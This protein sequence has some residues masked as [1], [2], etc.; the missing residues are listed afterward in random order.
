MAASINLFSRSQGDLTVEGLTPNDPFS[1]EE[2]SIKAQLATGKIKL[3]DAI[4]I[5]TYTA[6][7]GARDSYFVAN[8]KLKSWSEIQAEIKKLR[9]DAKFDAAVLIEAARSELVAQLSKP[10]DLA[11]GGSAFLGLSVL[12]FSV[13]TT[14]D[15]NVNLDLVAL[16]SGPV[17][18]PFLTAALGGSGQI[19]TV[20][21]QANAEIRLELT[22]SRENVADAVKILPSISMPPLPNFPA[23]DL[24]WPKIKWP[25]LDWPSLDLSG[26]AKLL[27][28][29]LP[30]SKSPV[31]IDWDKDA[32]GKS[33]LNLKF[34]VDAQKRLSVGTAAPC[35]GKLIYVDGSNAPPAIADINGFSFALTIGGNL[36]VA[37]IVTPHAVSPNLPA[38]VIDQPELLPFKIELPASTLTIQVPTVNLSQVQ[39]TALG[40]KAT[41]E[42]KRI[43]IRAKND[44]ALLIALHA[45]Y[46]QSVEA[47][48]KTSGQ[49]TTLEIIEPY[50]VKLITVAAQKAEDLARQLLRFASGIRMPDSSFQD[51]SDL[52]KVLDRIADMVAAAVR[53]LTQ[54]GGSI[55]NPLLG[56]A[57]AV[58]EVLAR[59]VHM[60]RDAIKKIGAGPGVSPPHLMIEVRLDARTYALRQIVIAPAWGSSLTT[61]SFSGEELGLSLDIKV[62]LI[63]QPSV[64]IDLDGAPSVA[65]LI[66]PPAAAPGT[67]PSATIGTDLW[68]GHD[69][70]L[71]AVRDTDLQG[72]RDAK[73]L[74]QADIKFTN[75][76]AIALVRLADGA[77]HFLQACDA[78]V[79]ATQIE[80]PG[81]DFPTGLT[82]ATISGDITYKGALDWQNVDATVS[83][84]TDRLLPFLQSSQS[85]DSGALGVLNSIGQYIKVSAQSS[86]KPSADGKCDLPVN[87]SLKINDANV[88]FDLHVNIDLKDFSVKLSGADKIAI[89]GDSDKTDFSLLGLTGNIVPKA[90]GNWPPKTK[91]PFFNLDFSTGDAHLLLAPE[92]RLDLAYGKVASGGRGIVFHVD[93]LGISRSGLDLDAKV[94]RDTPV[95]LA[96]VD[97]PFRFDS[98]G[99]SIKHGQIQAFSIKGSGQLPPELVGEANATISISMGRGSDGSLIV[100]SAE[101]K[102]DKAGDPIVCHATRFVLTISALG[103]EFQNF[104]R[105]GGGY[106]FY[107]TL[108]GTAEFR[109]GEGEFTD[110]LLKYLGSITIVLD[111]A[112]LA[113]DSSMLLRAISFQV[114]VVPPK[115]VNFFNLFSF[116]LR[117]I[118]FHP[119]SPAFGGKPALSIS[120]QVN[121]VESG[122]IVSPRFDFH[123]LWIAPPKQGQ[124]L[125][126]IRFDGLTLGVRFGGAASIEGT[127]IAV[128]G[129]LPSLYAPGALPTDVTV[130]GFLASG[131]L[132]IKGWGA[133]AA[134]MGFLE[135]RKDGGDLRRAFFLYAE[136]DDLSIEIPTPIGPIYLRE[137]GFGFGYRFTIAAFN[138]ADKVTSVK[139]LI[140]VLDDISKYQGNLAS[141]K[142]WEPEAE[143]NRVTLAL[144]GLITIESASEET[145]YN[146]DGEEDLPNPILFDIVV[147]LRSDFTFFLNARVWI[148]RNYADWHDSSVNDF[149]RNNPTLRG[150][151][152]LSVPRK[153]FLGRLI[154]D[155]TGD[156][157]GKH[158]QLPEPLVKAMKGIRWSATTYIRPGL[159]HQEFGWPYELGFTFEEKLGGGSFQIVCSGG[160]INRIEDGAMLWGIA[161]RAKGY[162]QFGGQIGGRSFGASAYARADF[163]IDAK[164]IA[165]ISVKRFSDTLFYGSISFDV[166]IGLQVRIWLEFSVGFTDIHLEVG[167]SISLTISIALEAAATPNSISARGSASVAVG[168][169]GRHIRLGVAFAVN[170]GRLDEARAR[171]ERF[172]Q[173]GLTSSM[174]DAEQAVAP[175]AP[176]LPRG[177]RAGSA[178]QAADTGLD[179]HDALNANDPPIP[180]VP[181]KPLPVPEGRPLQPT[182]YWAMLFPVAGNQPGGEEEFVMIFVPR[183]HTETGLT[184]T[185]LPRDRDGQAF[186]SFYPPPLQLDSSVDNNPAAFSLVARAGMPATFKFNRLDPTS[187]VQPVALGDM[188]KYKTDWT[189]AVSGSNK[190]DLGTFLSQC[191]IRKLSTTSPPPK[192]PALADLAEPLDTHIMADP[193]RLPSA[194]EAAAQVLTDAGRDQMSLGL[195]LRA[196]NDI[197]ERRSA[198]IASLCDSAAKLAAGGRSSWQ[199]APAA[200]GFDIRT[201]GAAFVVKKTE[202]DVLFEA[203][204]S[205]GPPRAGK[206]DIVAA[207]ASIPGIPQGSN[208][209]LFNSP[210]RMFRERGPRLAEP[211]V[212]ATP[213]GIR[214]DWDLEPPFGN[215]RGVW[216]DPEFDLKH[217][218]IER[219]VTKLDGLTGLAKPMRTT[220]KAAAPMR[221][222]RDPVSGSFVWRFV[223]PNAQFVDDLSDLP[224]AMR[225][226]IL[227]P[228]TVPDTAPT[229][230]ASLSAIAAPP[231]VLR[232]T[233]VP[234]DTA[235]TDGAPTPLVL[236]TQIVK[237]PRKGVKRAV[238]HFEYRA[239]SADAVMVDVTSPS[240]KPTFTLGIDD[241]SDDLAKRDVLKNNRRYLLR[242]RIEQTVPIGLYGSDAVSDAK[243]RPSAGDFAIR[244][245]GDPD[246]FVITLTKGTITPPGEQPAPLL[247]PNFDDPMLVN[248]ATQIGYSIDDMQRFLKV[249]GADRSPQDRLDNGPIGVRFAIQ[250]AYSVGSEAEPPWCPMD[251]SILI[252][253]I[254]SKDKL[255]AV[256]APVEVFEHPVRV[257]VAP[258]LSEDIDGNAGRIVVLHPAVKA[259][260]S[261]APATL[262]QLLDPLKESPLQRLRDSARRV[263]TSVQWN[264]RPAAIERE[265]ADRSARRNASYFG[266]YDIFE[267][268][269]VG[270][271]EGATS[272]PTALALPYPFSKSVVDSNPGNSLRYNDKV[273]PEDKTVGA[274]YIGGDQMFELDALNE[275]GVGANA[276]IRLIAADDPT[277]ALTLDL[278]VYVRARGYRKLLV[279]HGGSA[280]P[281]V[282]GKKVILFLTCDPPA[283]PVARVQA[284][285]A[286]LAQLD[287]AEIADFAKVEAHYP[288]ETLRLIAPSGGRQSGWYSPAESFLVWPKRTLRRSLSINVDEPTLTEMLS[289]GRPETIRVE[290]KITDKLSG[291]VLR[292]RDPFGKTGYDEVL[293]SGL[294]APNGGKW[295]AGVLREFLQ[296]LQWDSHAAEVRA[297]F[298]ENPD[299][300][301]RAT[302]I[303]SALKPSGTAGAPDIVLA[304]AQ[305]GIDLDPPLHP[306]LADVI[307][308]ARYAE[309]PAGAE[310]YPSVVLES[311]EVER[312]AA[313]L[314]DPGANFG[315]S[316]AFSINGWTASAQPAL[317]F[318][319]G[320]DFDFS[321][322]NFT[323]EKIDKKGVVA[324]HDKIA[325]Q[326]VAAAG[327]LAVKLDGG[328]L[329]ALK[330]NDAPITASLA[331]DLGVAQNPA[332][333]VPAPFKFSVTALKR[334][335]YRRYEPVLEQLPKVNAKDVLGWFDETPVQ[336]DPYGWSILR[337]LGLAAGIKLYDTE[338]RDYMTPAE[339]L[340]QLQAAF[341]AILPRYRHDDVG[342]PFVD[343]ITHAGGTLSLASFDGGMSGVS[344]NEAAALL[345]GPAL[346][347]A[348]ISLRPTVDRFA[349]SSVDAGTETEG[350]TPKSI[351]KIA[352]YF[353]IQAKP[354]VKVTLD[355]DKLT[356]A[357]KLIAVAEVI[358]LTTGLAKP[359]IVTLAPKSF[360]PAL[361][362]VRKAMLDGT[363]GEQTTLEIT[364]R[365]QRSGDPAT[366]AIVRV[367]VSSGDAATLF[368]PDGSV[369]WVANAQVKQ[370]TRP[371]DFASTDA[372]AFGR[373]P[374]LAAPRVKALTG[375]KGHPSLLNAIASLKS[376]TR[377]RLPEGWPSAADEPTLVAR[378]PDW[379]RRFFDHGTPTPP[380]LCQA[381]LFAIAEVT[382]PDPW[383]VGVAADGTMQVTFVHD[384]RKRRLKRYA[385]KPFGRYDGFADALLHASD[386]NAIPAPPRLGGAW[387]D[388]LANDPDLQQTFEDNWSRRFFDVVIPRTEPLAPPVLVDAKRIEILP[389][390]SAA[391]Q[392]QAPS[393]KALEFLFA[394][395]AEEI[396]SEANVTVE[397][398]LSFETVSYGFWREFPMQTW[399]NDIQPGI[400][401]TQGF[402][403]WNNRPAVPKLI[404]SADAFGG[405]AIDDKGGAGRYPEGWR[406]AL[407]LRTESLPFFFRTHVAAFAS[408]GVVVSDPVVATVEEGYYELALPWQTGSAGDLEVS[409]PAP[410]WSVSRQE[411]PLP[412]GLWVT[413]ELPL[414]RLFDSM[415]QDSRKAWLRGRAI[416]D[417]FMLP[418]PVVRYEIA[419]V[420]ADDGGMS[421]ASTELDI[422]GQQ[423]ATTSGSPPS[424]FGMNLVGPLFDPKGASPP[425]LHRVTN[426]ATW[427]LCPK[428]LAFEGT[429]LSA[430]FVPSIKPPEHPSGTGTDAL[431]LFEIKP[432]DFV[433][434]SGIAP[435]RTVLFTV[436]PPVAPAGWPAFKTGVTAWRALYMPYI[437][438]S[439]G[440]KG[441]TDFLDQWINANPAAP[442]SLKTFSTDAFIAGLPRLTSP[443]S[444]VVFKQTSLQWLWPSAPAAGVDQRAA[445]RAIVPVTAANYSATEFTA[446]VANPIIAEM[447]R[448]LATGKEI[449]SRFMNYP[450]LT[451]ALPPGALADDARKLGEALQLPDC[452]DVVMSIPVAV[453]ADP[454]LAAK[455]Q[456]LLKAVE[457][458]KFTSVAILDLGALEDGTA[459]NVELHL[460]CGVLAKA[461]VQAALDA[462]D[463]AASGGK[464]PWSLLLR[465]PPED[466]DRSKIMT[467][468]D[469]VAGLADRDALKRFYDR[470]MADQIFGVGRLPRVKAYRGTSAPQQDQIARKV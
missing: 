7:G 418:D 262:A 351:D 403:D 460:S 172:M 208:V 66:A 468:I 451:V 333:P 243:A 446:G 159:F 81:R 336:R 249:I 397:G 119:S 99:L 291:M 335:K 251:S 85:T 148:A 330:L 324:T 404:E 83:A 392:A 17:E 120:G 439:I 370:I 353:A 304:S 414:V 384:D 374:D 447:R 56:V 141:I 176:E 377:K 459:E 283:K 236:Q 391:G 426:T 25:Q 231:Y 225:R 269:A 320:G 160:M 98:G 398:A 239:N 339:T 151:V 162:A 1:I 462:L 250:P 206:F 373:F 135:L 123:E 357:S 407:A 3:R 112:P 39:A 209:H 103:F 355:L 229:A 186:S 27:R 115:Q 307:D 16:D 441:I 131:K 233:V 424:C 4:K 369:P 157:D 42:L 360:D 24:H 279:K 431:Q 466:A 171:V 74:I 61:E 57:E 366:V 375:D 188:V 68:L 221:L 153:E 149:W 134:A 44:P 356:G 436:V 329:A 35:D 311:S 122:D 88:D 275:A 449:D 285:P 152:Y 331:L 305:W 294:K 338:Q 207:A 428:V 345:T 147:A 458:E 71:E 313:W 218:R 175:P 73:R 59:L 58:G 450:S 167:F 53:W 95:Q 51:P 177:P 248:R 117:G 106:Q 367:I 107:F 130:N 281:F 395:H 150:Y 433:A 49:L 133:M 298:A 402:G 15:A 295:T 168:A 166:S 445:I 309:A 432:T 64:V 161:F 211:I 169:F 216:F 380:D 234:V 192:V 417:V 180:T 217:Y 299:Q 270:E 263:G 203:G 227:P 104:A 101:A 364:A 82:V 154:A 65:L 55:R 116:E 193:E 77:V 354:S 89:L 125:P 361:D 190:M 128:D 327:R 254:G 289:N 20:A 114:A 388:P 346:S 110:G 140:K 266:G 290:L 456:A 96:G 264:A 381:P 72:K 29:D 409:T 252:D 144:R 232:Y 260:A 108:T 187:G 293:G 124:S 45:V 14:I 34:D 376:Y 214:L 228:T 257:D 200:T 292:P 86:V 174:P 308:F 50:P 276:Q 326:I 282:D 437:A 32:V 452:T 465:Q 164:F 461:G 421:S 165:Y 278:K 213:N 457:A 328:Q 368:G 235:G 401:T 198:T 265:L 22:V 136:A 342:S 184:S 372:G 28:F 109:P 362:D 390:T 318:Q 210:E 230:P 183:D 379:T 146:A 201:L 393:R 178:D 202:L 350:W 256:A 62:P 245:P 247:Q 411:P 464:K 30:I 429:A 408:A 69:S 181:G 170:P 84:Q 94:D 52:G 442:P 70:G 36:A 240:F 191:F 138:R 444:D 90:G 63:W 288:S 9:D 389:P 220:T 100:Q 127:A 246:D 315:E 323:I 400:S 347:L 455:V 195:E 33:K 18:A 267:L 12:P 126:Q 467:A 26:L 76:N 463:P 422:M 349:Q 226:A 212:E 280:I 75:V 273:D 470:A 440:A 113:R 454:G 430:D 179:K 224:D 10:I 325:A 129:S 143:G 306:L 215:S 385:I 396:L 344:A 87:V 340:K 261:L 102:L 37:G 303:L 67:G 348:Q 425:Y 219:I 435:T 406:G 142:S 197:E 358:D 46:T 383:R 132:S 253:I 237:Q 31:R 121:F 341:S 321:T 78:Q 79:S 185:E 40:I 268:D 412:P 277:K 443:S 13:V 386:P 272:A 427:N 156:V 274:I 334:P 359:P 302:I 301:R 205:D 19:L 371:V 284:L 145:E 410:T 296:N 105:E 365:G 271:A 111:K 399:A 163:S 204:S 258:L 244:R 343:V 453:K 137:V 297:A 332:H 420:A 60:L 92:A 41:L 423:R 199:A 448:V 93:D 287:P 415:P 363:G 387:S 413:I 394:R 223:R 48:G 173:L 238:L 378:I 43:V 286:S 155:G 438:M 21:G 158:P 469:G 312:L 419:V 382:R 11:A 6:D 222:V 434:F 352:A 2:I 8:G 241:G 91:V 54:Q 47:S 38:A 319:L 97:M 139:D 314:A 242:V 310:Q 118:G 189:V 416:P 316:V 255:P 80:P 196:A 23:L 194:R 405:L 337:T 259:D 182:A 5:P 317:G 300:F 322:A